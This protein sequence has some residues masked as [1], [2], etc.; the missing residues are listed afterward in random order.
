MKYKLKYLIFLF[1]VLLFPICAKANDV[2]IY[3]FHS[4]DCS[5]C[6]A[7][8]K[9]LEE[10]KENYDNVTVQKYEVT[11]NSDNASLE[12]KVKKQFNTTTPL[13]PF[14]VIG[15]K[16]FIG[17]SDDTKSGITKMIDKYSN[18]EHRDVV[19]EVIN[20]IDNGIINNGDKLDDKFTI[21]I[22]GEVNAK[23]VSLPIIAIV[24]G[25]VDGFNP[26]AMWVLIFLI[27]MLMG[28]KNKKRMWILGLTFLVTSALV[29]VLFMFAWL[30]IAVSLIEVMWIRYLISIVALVGAFIN[31]KSFY[32]S[33]T[34]KDN[35]CE[36]V[37]DTKRKR[38]M[39]YIKKFTAEKHFILALLGVIGLALAVN[40]IELACSAGLPLMF[41]QILALNNLNTIQ[42]IIYVAL[43][44]LFFLIDDIV[45]FIVAMFTLQ[46]TGISTKYTKYSHLIGGIIMLLIGLLMIFK[47]SWLMFNF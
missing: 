25:F 38:I 27:S 33:V 47:P 37:N 17:F 39:K 43:Y 19:D 36:V 29:Y 14:T 30:N 3:L 15:E 46:L 26:C 5:H 2:N 6:K 23:N 18:E 16:Y 20:G 45:V 22:I 13:V 40:L 21:P 4:Q 32:K 9:W 42:T 35:G 11:R 44:I 34:K 28:M 1:I 41:T 10:I 31:L 12:S 8:I 24:I 7:E